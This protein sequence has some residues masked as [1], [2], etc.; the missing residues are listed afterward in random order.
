MPAHPKIKAIIFDLGNVLLDF[1]HLRAASRLAGLTDKSAQQI[2]DLFFDSPVTGLFEAGRI[3][4]Q[5][6]FLKVKDM[7]GL[8][9]DFTQF[10]PIWNEIF[11]LS[12][13]NKAVKE[14]AL[15]L[16]KNYNITLLSNINVLHLEYIKNNFPIFEP[17]HNVLA[18]CDLGACKPNAEVYQK[19]LDA[20]GSLPREVFYTDDRADLIE[21]ARQIGIQGFVFTGIQQLKADLS[22]LGVCIA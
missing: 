6:F 13:K 5:D 1:D 3:S 9:I 11:F 14:L 15:R 2:Y 22:N 17:F 18:S 20:S 19:A 21:C 8:K 12:D 7:L 10:L 4:P 16:K